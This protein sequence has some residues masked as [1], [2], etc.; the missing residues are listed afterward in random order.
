MSQ[1]RGPG[2]VLDAVTSAEASAGS[3]PAVT[4]LVAG[5]DA[6]DALAVTLESLAGQ[7]VGHGGLEVVV[8]SVRPAPATREV[9]AATRAGSAHPVR[10]VEG[11]SSD[12]RT[13]RRL[14]LLAARVRK[15]F[16]PSA[17][18]RR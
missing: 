16:A 5:G 13:R 6:A 3:R 10:L 18:S 17:D 14:A 1:V 8:Q 11:G 7:S 2:A 15:R 12:A 9:V 4:V